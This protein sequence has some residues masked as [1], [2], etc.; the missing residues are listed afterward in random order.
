MSPR[1]HKYQLLSKMK[2]EDTDHYETPLSLWKQVLHDVPRD[3]NTI[4]F[5]P[6]YCRGFSEKCFSTLGFKYIRHPNPHEVNEYYLDPK[7]QNAASRCT[8]IVTNPPFSCLELALADLYELQKPFICI[9]P[10]TCLT[11]PPVFEYITSK[12]PESRVLSLGNP[13]FVRHGVRMPKPCGFE[14]IALFHPA[15]QLET[16]ESESDTDI[17]DDIVLPPTK[18]AKFGNS[19]HTGNGD[20]IAAKGD[21]HLIKQL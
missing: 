10:E 11:N 6:F 16:S 9:L 21:V 20:I 4:L 15:V 7:V 17:D 8:L 3:L 2:I 1:K 19:T 13:R 5:D 12:W 18:R 14:C